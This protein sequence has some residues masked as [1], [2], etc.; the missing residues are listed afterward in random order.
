MEKP[1]RNFFEIIILKEDYQKA[2]KK[3][4]LIKGFELNLFQ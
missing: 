3:V 2:L 4:N 1:C